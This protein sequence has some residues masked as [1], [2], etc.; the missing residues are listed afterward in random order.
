MGI[1]MEEE[2]GGRAGKERKKGE[3]KRKRKRK[4]KNEKIRST[5]DTSL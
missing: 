5:I 1:F 2:K 4:R 3:R